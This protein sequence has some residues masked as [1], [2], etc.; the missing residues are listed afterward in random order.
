[1]VQLLLHERVLGSDL[2]RLTRVGADTPMAVFSSDGTQ[3]VMMG[4]DGIYL[5]NADGSNLCKIDPLGDHGGL[6]WVWK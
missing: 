3:I 5:M 2:Q 4:E 6:D 1:M